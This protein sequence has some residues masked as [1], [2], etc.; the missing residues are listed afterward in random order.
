MV[1][2]TRP[3]LI[4]WIYE[5]TQAQ[6][7]EFRKRSTKTQ[8]FSMSLFT[9]TRT[10]DFTPVALQEIGTIVVRVRDSEGNCSTS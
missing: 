3:R 5:L 6:G 2:E 7:M 8:M 1:C 4:K 9:F 10:A